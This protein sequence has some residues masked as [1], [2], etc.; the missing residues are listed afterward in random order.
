VAEAVIYFRYKIYEQEVNHYI[1]IELQWDRK[2]SAVGATAVPVYNAS[3]RLEQSNIEVSD[4]CQLHTQCHLSR[5]LSSSN[6]HAEISG[7]YD[8][9]LGAT[10]LIIRFSAYIR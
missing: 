7:S 5:V 6:L 10:K 8:T 4:S 2:D 3:D 9:H 1:H